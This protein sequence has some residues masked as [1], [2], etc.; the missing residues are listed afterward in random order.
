[1]TR[2]QIISDTHQEF[3]RK[4]AFT[5]EEIDADALIHCGD[6]TAGADS[7]QYFRDLDLPVFYV[8]GNHEFYKRHWNE[9]IKEY[10]AQ[11]D[12]TRVSVLEDETVVFN[13]IRII[14]ATLWTNF[15]APVKHKPFFD[16]TEE[17][18]PASFYIENQAFYCKQSMSDF[19]LIKMV[20]TSGWRERHNRSVDYI[21]LVLSNKFDGPT[22]VMTHHA[23]SFQSSHPKWE[24]SAI[25]G[26]FCSN[27]EWIIEEYQPDYW[28]H[29]HCHEPFNYR[30]GN[31][32]IICNPLGY[33]GENDSKI[34]QLIVEL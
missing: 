11:F 6:A 7:V 34:K 23:P 1:V 27:L 14:G 20:T 24:D 8:L 19:D 9:A 28:F 13:G 25:R 16:A 33:P 3:R 26:G 4:Q 10:K 32:T 12:G 5:K 29:G 21:K 31:T 2:L 15:L 17:N 18:S 30:I 22:V